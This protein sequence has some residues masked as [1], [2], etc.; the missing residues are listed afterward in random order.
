M[1]TELVTALSFREGEIS[2]KPEDIDLA[3]IKTAFR[4]AMERMKRN[5]T[6]RGQRT[7]LSRQRG[8][9]IIIRVKLL[10]KLRNIAEPPGARSNQNEI[11]FNKSLVT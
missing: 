11:N 9:K 7:S 3:H 8:Q 4:K 10:N 6:V 1:T 2:H 5:G